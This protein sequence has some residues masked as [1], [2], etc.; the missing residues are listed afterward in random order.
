MQVFRRSKFVLRVNACIFILIL[1]TILGCGNLSNSP[2]SKQSYQGGK[3]LSIVF[4]GTRNIPFFIEENKETGIALSLGIHVVDRKSNEVATEIRQGKAASLA[5]PK[6]VATLSTLYLATPFASAVCPT[7]EGYLYSQKSEGVN[8]VG[9]NEN[10][11]IVMP[12]PKA[13]E[14]ATINLKLI[15]AGKPLS[16]VVVSIM[17]PL[18]GTPLYDTCQSQ[19]LGKVSDK[20]GLLSIKVPYSS[21]AEDRKNGIV[22]AKRAL[23]QISQNDKKEFLSFDFEKNPPKG[24]DVSISAIY[25]RNTG[26][27]AFE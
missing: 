4:A 9:D 6:G 17:N 18:S 1:F 14:V 19:Y 21:K 15:G 10:Y 8:F 3:K 2:S 20:A 16:G 13:A 27:I 26:S 7:P 12:L 5:L 25:D 11:K 24:G 23:L 22:I